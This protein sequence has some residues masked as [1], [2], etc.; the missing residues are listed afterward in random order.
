MSIQLGQSSNVITN[1]R[2]TRF[3]L[4]LCEGGG[5][6][7]LVVLRSPAFLVSNSRMINGKYRALIWQGREKK[8]I[9]EVLIFKIHTN[10]HKLT[11]SNAQEKVT[12]WISSK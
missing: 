2:V 11:W 9:T 3:C 12:L 10:Y 6:H 8:L 1:Y 4:G 5:E 7:C